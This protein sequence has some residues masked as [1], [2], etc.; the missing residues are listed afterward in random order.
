MAFCECL[1]AGAAGLYRKFLG[2]DTLEDLAS[3]LSDAKIFEKAVSEI[4][5]RGYG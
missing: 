5:A 3:W 2:M 4:K 1:H